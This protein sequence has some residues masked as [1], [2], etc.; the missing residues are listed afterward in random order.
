[1]RNLN[2]IN[3]NPMEIILTFINDEGLKIFYLTFFLFILL[4]N[5]PCIVCYIHIW[6]RLAV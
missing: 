3:R 5:I 6:S 1:M 2:T 4:G